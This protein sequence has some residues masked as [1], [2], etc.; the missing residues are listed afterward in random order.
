[1][2]G[3][4]PAAR[5]GRAQAAEVSPWTAGFQPAFAPRA[6]AP[7]GRPRTDSAGAA[8]GW[9]PAV[10][11]EGEILRPFGRGSRIVSVGFPFLATPGAWM[12]PGF[13]WIDRPRL[14]ALARPQ[15]ADDLRWLRRHGIDVLV[16]L[17]EDPL[18]RDWVNDAG[19][20]A[21]PVPV[22]DMEP[23]TE[24]QLDHILA[25]VARAHASGMGVAIH[26]AAGLGRTGTAVAAYLV[27]TGLS[28]REALRKVRELRPGSVETLDQERAVEQYARRLAARPADPPSEA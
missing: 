22:S 23:P 27:G 3:R 4:E 10:R 9:K 6:E 25:T 20:L 18:P 21:V 17:T 8:A 5:R 14:A 19:L 28:A 2:A 13:S 12:P 26:C 16:S 1:M 15:S 7:R 11:Q 24:R